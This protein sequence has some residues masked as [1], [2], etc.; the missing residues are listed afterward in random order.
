M[1]QE[2]SHRHH[3]ETL[4]EKHGLVVED[5]KRIIG[6][7]QMEQEELRS[8]TQR[9]FEEQQRLKQVAEGLSE[10]LEQACAEIDRLNKLLK[11]RE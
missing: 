1:A 8:I 2:E 4:H 9:H 7:T 11:D 3:V 10:E 6:E 5:Y